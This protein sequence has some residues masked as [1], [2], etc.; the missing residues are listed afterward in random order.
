MNEQLDLSTITEERFWFVYRDISWREQA[1]EIQLVARGDSI[2]HRLTVRSERS[3]R[4]SQPITALLVPRA[5][6]N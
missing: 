6:S 3:E 4:E 1:P 2:E 5:Q